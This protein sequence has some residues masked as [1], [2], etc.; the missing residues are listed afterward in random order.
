M[1][2]RA[3]VKLY[4]RLK[5]TQ[6][7]NVTYLTKK[8]GV[9]VFWMKPLYFFLIKID[10]STVLWFKSFIL[11]LFASKMLHTKKETEFGNAKTQK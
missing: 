4:K 8:I 5:C 1:R 9:F 6:K 2:A 7:T 3:R 11:I 10:H